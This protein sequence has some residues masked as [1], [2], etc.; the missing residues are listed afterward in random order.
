MLLLS[1]VS[2]VWFSPETPIPRAFPALW[3][4][5]APLQGFTGGV[6]TVIRAKSL[7]KGQWLKTR[8]FETRTSCAPHRTVIAYRASQRSVFLYGFAKSER[9][10]IDDRELDDLKKLAR[11]YLNYSDA[12]IATALARTELKEVICDAQEEA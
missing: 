7:A 8:C 9:D 11:H 10:N 6:H 3:I 1:P 5:F 12:Q 4:F 2:V